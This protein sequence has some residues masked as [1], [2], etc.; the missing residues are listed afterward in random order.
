[1]LSDS[2]APGK[3]FD[4]ASSRQVGW[5][6]HLP[7]WASVLQSTFKRIRGWRVPPRWSVRDWSEELK[8]LSLAA[9]WHAL[10]DFDPTYGVP[11]DVFLRERILASALTRY[12]QEWTYSVR[13]T[14]EVQNEGMYCSPGCD[15]PAH[16][17]FVEALARLATTDRWLIEQ[18]FWHGKSEA[19]VSKHLGISQQAVNKRKKSVLRALRQNFE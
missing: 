2:P 15:R 1:M 17:S 11:L 19:E 6:G 18:I 8:A 16:E 5:A 14:E 10:G 7:Q 4:S 13:C 12:R 9:A 3:Q